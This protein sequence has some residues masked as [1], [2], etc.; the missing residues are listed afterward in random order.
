MR[1]YAAVLA[2]LTL[3]TACG[4][5]GESG[6]DDRPTV[7]E[8]LAEAREELDSQ[9]PGVTADTIRV[10]VTYVDTEAVRDI[11]DLDHGDYEAAY[12]ALFEDLNAAGGIHGRRIEPV[13]AAI[14]P[15]SA[16][17][18]EVACARFAR[19]EGVFLVMGFV[20]ADA[21][22]CYL[23]TYDTAVIGGAMTAELREAA[24]PPWF[25]ADASADLGAEVIRAYAEQGALEG[26]LGVVALSIDEAQLGR[27]VVPLLDELGIEPVAS[28]LIDDRVEG[29]ATASSLIEG[30][31]VD[32]IAERFDD[33]GVE[34]VLVIGPAGGAWTYG[35]ARTDYRPELLYTT[36]GGINAYVE[37]DASDVSLLEGARAGGLYEGEEVLNQPAMQECLGTQEAAGVEVIPDDSPLP[38]TSAAI[39]CR[40]V[41]LFRAIAEAAGPE[42]TYGDFRQAGEG[43]GEVT[44]P[45]YPDPFRYGAA[46]SAD[47]DPAAYLFRWDAASRSFVAEGR[48]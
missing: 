39:A 3:V 47:G 22:P 44:I 10:G 27:E 31:S 4:S 23:E 30:S 25:T 7:E 34:K 46:A 29:E 21:L 5:D 16:T 38:I 28:G 17:D 14:S 9:A 36:L 8:V 45:G 33:A 18:G 19:E 41:A 1:K 12:R 20:Q 13:F 35:L 43:L 6:N 2:A 32:E 24:D 15:I 11:I 26:R 37:D 40:N 42:M 48:S